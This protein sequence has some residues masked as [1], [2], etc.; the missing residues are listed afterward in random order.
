MYWLIFAKCLYWL[1]FAKRMYWF[2]FARGCT[3]LPLLKGCTGLSLPEVVQAYLCQKVVEFIWVK[4]LNLSQLL[5][6]RLADEWR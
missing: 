4:S 5:C 6:S 2:I 3:G 1:A